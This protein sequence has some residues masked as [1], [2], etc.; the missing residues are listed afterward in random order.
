MDE[1][2]KFLF[3]PCMPG[4][5]SKRQLALRALACS[6]VSYHTLN[7]LW[8]PVQRRDLD[9]AINLTQYDYVAE[10]LGR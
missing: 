3:R 9:R 2:M 4:K 8:G 10:Q 6:S 7:R 5:P 1:R